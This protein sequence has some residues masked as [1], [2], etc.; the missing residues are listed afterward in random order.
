VA[1][2]VVICGVG[3]SSMLEGRHSPASSFAS[4]PGAT[5][6]A[7]AGS[8]G[9]TTS[10][11]ARSVQPPALAGTA[12]SRPGAPRSPRLVAEVD[13]STAPVSPTLAPSPTPTPTPL[14]TPGQGPPRSAFQASLVFEPVA[15]RLDGPGRG[16]RRSAEGDGAFPAFAPTPAPADSAWAAGQ[17][18]HL[19]GRRG[20]VWSPGLGRLADVGE[21]TTAFA[22]DG[23]GAVP[24]ALNA[25]GLVP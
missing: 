11:E 6:G 21:I 3:T 14:R 16:P 24:A 25:R 1:S 13:P 5:L 18:Q 10:I 9:G 22:D 15:A 23:A 12:G 8:T 4:S 19:H 17:A 2:V 7:Q 20:I